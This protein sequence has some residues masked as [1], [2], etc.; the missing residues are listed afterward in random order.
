MI[1]VELDLEN[2]EKSSYSVKDNDP[3]F[4]IYEN[5]NNAFVGEIGLNFEEN[6]EKLFFQ[7]L[8]NQASFIGKLHSG[9]ALINVNKKEKS[10]EIFRD[11]FGIKPLYFSQ[12]AN[13]FIITSQI[14]PLALANQKKLNNEHIN[15]YLRAE[16]D[17]NQIG[18]STFFEN[19]FRILPGH[20]YHIS[21]K[22]ISKTLIYNSFEKPL[23]S[24][25]TILKKI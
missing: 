5:E 21:K 6:F 20:K 18:K 16:Y 14:K 10:I 23:E 3:D 8:E 19:V 15:D 7:F 9:F 2:F 12:I 24:F 22:G 4:F 1:K 17:D 11:F 25:K 13:K